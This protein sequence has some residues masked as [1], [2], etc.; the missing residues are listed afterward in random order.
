MEEEDE[1]R[2]ATTSE[3]RHM[4]IGVAFGLTIGLFLFLVSL[5]ADAGSQT[6]VSFDQLNLSYRE[7]GMKTASGDRLR[8]TVSRLN[9]VQISE[10]SY[11]Y[12]NSTCTSWV[13]VNGSAVTAPVKG[14]VLFDAEEL[15][16]GFDFE[17]EYVV[18]DVSAERQEKTG[19]GSYV[20][21]GAD[22]TGFSGSLYS[23]WDDPGFEDFNVH[24]RGQE[25]LQN[26]TGS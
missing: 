14:V 15:R 20:Y 9:E 24:E 5:G 21:N 16:I 2:E 13:T 17:E 23:K 25:L 4:I 1:V 18:C 22:C 6:Q 11:V 10:N 19:K 3:K 26:Q 12:R 8:C 7:I